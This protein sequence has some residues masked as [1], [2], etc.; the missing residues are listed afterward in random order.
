MVVRGIV[1]GAVGTD[2]LNTMYREYLRIAF[3]IGFLVVRDLKRYKFSLYSYIL[4]KYL[5]KEIYL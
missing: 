1:S 3:Y 4:Y 5:Y 2:F